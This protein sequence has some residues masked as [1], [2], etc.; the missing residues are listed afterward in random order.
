MARLPTKYRKSV[1]SRR[2]LYQF[3]RKS[4]DEKFGRVKMGMGRQKGGTR[5]VFRL[6]GFW[7]STPLSFLWLVTWANKFPLC[8]CYFELGL[9]EL[10]LLFAIKRLLTKGFWM[11]GTWVAQLVKCLTSAQVMTLRFMGLNSALGSVLTAQSQ[12]PASDSVSPS[13]SLPLPCLLSLSQK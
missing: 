1:F 11:R 7:I 3:T 6:C 10:S 9:V 8:S 12:E 5:N 13:L 4:S 2:D